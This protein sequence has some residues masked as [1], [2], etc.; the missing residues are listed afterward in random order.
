[1]FF[2]S[3]FRNKTPSVR[4]EILGII[5]KIERE[6]TGQEAPMS[7]EA[8]QKCLDVISEADQVRERMV[9]EVLQLFRPFQKS[10]EMM[11]FYKIRACLPVRSW[12]EYLSLDRGYGGEFSVIYEYVDCPRIRRIVS[13]PLNKLPMNQIGKVY[14]N[15]FRLHR[16]M[17]QCFRQLVI[18]KTQKAQS[19]IN[20]FK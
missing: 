4:E 15:R 11:T 18:E 17:V 7:D 3:L 19:F 10:M 1:M 6:N 2:R 5:D 8:I 14:L 16:D 12:N 13:N 9:E 20:D